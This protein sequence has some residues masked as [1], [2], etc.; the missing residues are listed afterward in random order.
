[1]NEIPLKNLTWRG[2]YTLVDWCMLTFK[3][4][5]RGTTWDY[6][7]DPDYVLYLN[8]HNYLLFVLRWQGTVFGL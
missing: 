8:D 7:D 4:D 1:M 3:P 5:N 2:I 6:R